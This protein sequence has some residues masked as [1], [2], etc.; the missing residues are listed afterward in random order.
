MRK[1]LVF[2]ALV[3][4]GFAQAGVVMADNSPFPMP[5]QLTDNS[6]FPMP[7]QLT[8]NSPFPMPPQ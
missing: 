4:F 1:Y 5:P 2:A 8:D 6:P 7:P 3:A